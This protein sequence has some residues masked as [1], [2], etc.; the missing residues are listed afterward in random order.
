MSSAGGVVGYAVIKGTQVPGN[1][2]VKSNG[3]LSGNWNY[4]GANINYNG[5]LNKASNSGSGTYSDAFGCFGSFSVS[6]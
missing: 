1:G 6:R 2:T 5:T 4:N 3:A